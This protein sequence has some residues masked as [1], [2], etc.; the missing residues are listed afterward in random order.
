MEPQVEQ[1]YS[2]STN[3]VESVATYLTAF[4]R[5]S[6]RSFYGECTEQLL[7]NYLRFR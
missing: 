6:V 2:L 4:L 1:S 7:L 3:Y 5:T